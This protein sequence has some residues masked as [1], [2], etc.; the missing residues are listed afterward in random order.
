VN[1]LT[2]TEVIKQ[3]GGGA[4][5]TAFFLVLARVGPLFVFA[6][7]FSSKTIPSRVRGIVAVGLAVGLTG[8][9]LRGQTPPTDPL[10]VTGVLVQNMLV[11]LAFAFAIGLVFSA[12]Q[13]AGTLTDAVS[14]FSFGAQVDP[15]SG[16]QGGAFTQLYGLVGLALF[17]A[18]G[19]D[20]WTLRGLAR[21]FSLVPLTR[22]P[23]LNGMV[24]G[25][26]QIFGSL[27]ASAIEVAAPVMLAMLIT[28]VAFGMVSKVVPQINLFGI[29]F[30]LKIGVALLVVSAALPFIG[31]W[32]SDQLAS[33]VGT[34]LQSISVH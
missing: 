24:A 22:G 10:G 5:V 9:A 26:E 11:G 18:I 7:L 12:V 1:Q 28:D 3:V 14:G 32:M 30:P 19:G 25:A 27:F 21:T 20:A 8:M 31:G 17:L 23:R 34:A 13:V 15:I 6:P 2:L 4:H 29:G 33:S 16:N